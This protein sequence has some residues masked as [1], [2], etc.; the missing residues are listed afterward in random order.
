M[1]VQGAVLPCG[2]ASGRRHPQPQR[3]GKPAWTC[4]AHPPA[5]WQPALWEHTRHRHQGSSPGDTPGA[6]PEVG[7]ASTPQW[8]HSLLA[9]ALYI[10]FY[11][12]NLL[13]RIVWSFAFAFSATLQPGHDRGYTPTPFHLLPHQDLQPGAVW[14]THLLP[15]LQGAAG[16]GAGGVRAG[17]TGAAGTPRCYAASAESPPA[18]RLT[19]CPLRKHPKNLLVSPDTRAAAE[20]AG[21][22]AQRSPGPAAPLELD[23]LPRY[24]NSNSSWVRDAPSSSWWLLPG[25]PGIRCAKSGGAFIMC[26]HFR[27]GTSGNRS[28][29]TYTEN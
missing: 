4:A 21:T 17:W 14:D 5:A 7:A 2:S 11:V 16:A 29:S 22:W 26:A 25:F 10:I 1:G 9:P 27:T 20:E 12:I 28:S 23:L 3:A 24:C 15:G 6:W 19:G 8:A 13:H 18:D